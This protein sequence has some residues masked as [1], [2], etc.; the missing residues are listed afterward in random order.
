METVLTSV[1]A[2]SE[3]IRL[4]LLLLLTDRE[5]CVCELMSVFDMAQ[6][7]LSHHLISLRDA[8]FLQDEKRGKWNYYRV[9]TGGLSAV[10]KELLTALTRR[11]IENETIRRDRRTLEKVRERMQICC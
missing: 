4:R 7:K 6:S 3:E 9:K 8:G 2:L 5:A 1:R 10:N 11:L